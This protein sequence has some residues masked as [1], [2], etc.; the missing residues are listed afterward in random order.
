MDP[1]CP[2]EFLLVAGAD[3]IASVFGGCGMVI[4][5]WTYGYNIMQNLGNKITLHSPPRGF[6]MELGN[7]STVIVATQLCKSRGYP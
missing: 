5:L 2:F 6:A 7:A 3:T 4:G 1:V